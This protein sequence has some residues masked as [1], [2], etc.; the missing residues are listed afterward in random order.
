[1]SI[2]YGQ[3]RVENLENLKKAKFC[4]Q[5]KSIT[6]SFCLNIIT[7]MLQIQIYK[8]RIDEN[9]KKNVVHQTKDPNSELVK[10]MPFLIKNA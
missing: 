3:S 7:V 5:A 8:K 9:R 2:S 1:M 10:K 4:I 6:E